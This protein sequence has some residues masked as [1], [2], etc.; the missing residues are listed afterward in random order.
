MKIKFLHKVILVLIS[1]QV[2]LHVHAQNSL[3]DSIKLNMAFQVGEIL[4]YNVNYGL[5]KAGKA[6]ITLG[7]KPVGYSYLF[8]SRAVA[9]T[10]GLASVFAEIEDI[11]ECYFEID[12]G[13]P[14][15]ASINI[16]ENK[17]KAY[18]EILFMN[19]SNKIISLKKG[20]RTVPANTHD[21]L[22]AFYYA[23]RFLFSNEYTKNQAIR[24][25]TFFDDEIIPIKLIYK[26]TE[27]INTEFGR[28]NSLKFVPVLEKN[29]PFKNENDFQVWFSNDNNYVP[30]KIKAKLR[31]GSIN[32]ELTGYQHLK[33]NLT[34]K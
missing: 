30:L 32:A 14:V 25:V 22:S 17:Y 27:T 10:A 13:L 16:H 26:K 23:R 28:I 5:I 21:I 9:T 1:F 33:T 7:L 24:L 4:T 18:N 20:K 19:D 3:T 2:S 6:T 15:K 34:T 12:N 8:Y 31:F 29:S 11:Y